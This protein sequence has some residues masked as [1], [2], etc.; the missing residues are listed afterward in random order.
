MVLPHCKIFKCVCVSTS[1][2]HTFDVTGLDIP[3]VA[4]FEKT[5]LSGC[6]PK[7]YC[8]CSKFIKSL[9]FSL[10]QKPNTFVIKVTYPIIQT[11]KYGNSKETKQI[12]FSRSQVQKN[13]CSRRRWIKEIPENQTQPLFWKKIFSAWKIQRQS[14]KHF[15]ERTSY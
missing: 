5:K 1:K 7:S 8:V 14:F 6:R 12:F 3:G 2:T 11:A 9:F 13:V 10:G 15:W 4:S